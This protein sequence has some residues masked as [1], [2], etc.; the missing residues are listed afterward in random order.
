MKFLPVAFMLPLLL[1]G[2]AM[3]SNH[4]AGSAAASTGYHHHGRAPG[5]PQSQPRKATL[6]TVQK[7]RAELQT[8]KNYK[9][10]IAVKEQSAT[11]A[12]NTSALS[13]LTAQHPS[14]LAVQSHGLIFQKNHPK[15]Q[16]AIYAHSNSRNNLRDQFVNHGGSPDAAKEHVRFV[17]DQATHAAE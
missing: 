10:A 2:S 9:A 11:H 4:Y 3:A 6:T 12:A 16:E 5:G 15:V 1:P 7:A 17:E 8:A 14:T 13:E